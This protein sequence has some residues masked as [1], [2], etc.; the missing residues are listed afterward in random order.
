MRG[1]QGTLYG[2]NTV[3]GAVNLIT[4]KLGG[5]FGAKVGVSV[6]DYD[7]QN[8]KGTANVPLVGP[9]GILNASSEQTLALKVAQAPGWIN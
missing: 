9:S 5:Y 4:R 6:G 8:V 2:R 7:R 1:P 3:G